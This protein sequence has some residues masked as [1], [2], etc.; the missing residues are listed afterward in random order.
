MPARLHVVKGDLTFDAGF[1]RP[2]FAL[3]RDTPGLLSQLYRRLEPHGLRLT[4]LRV[5]RG[6]GSVAD[7]HV[8]CYLF[9]YRMMV[10]IRVERIEVVCSDL[11]QDYIQK[12]EPG[13]TDTLWAVKDQLPNVA[14]RAFALAVGLH[15]QLE[16]QALRDYLGRFATNPP[17]ELGPLTGS[18]TV[19]YFGPEGDRLL[20]S[21]TVDMSALIPDALYVRAQAV[22]DATKLPLE[23]LS[24]QA[25]DF[26][27]SAVGRLG[28]E[29]PQ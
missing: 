21:V 9:N 17:K 24:V 10:R 16:G 8:L 12:F 26:V 13:I 29:L 11:P 1:V 22:W 18:G 23:S 19:F 6:T 28:L 25:Q 20:S 2:E 27:R 14:F 4:D 3:L 15:G 5:E 7:S